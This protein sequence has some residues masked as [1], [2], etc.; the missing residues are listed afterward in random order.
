MFSLGLPEV[1]FQNASNVICLFFFFLLW[2]EHGA[3]NFKRVFDFTTGLRKALLVACQ[4][5]QSELSFSM[6]RTG[7]FFNGLMESLL[8]I[9]TKNKAKHEATR[10]LSRILGHFFKYFKAV[11]TVVS[12]QFPC[13]TVFVFNYF[14]FVHYLVPSTFYLVNSWTNLVWEFGKECSMKPKSA[15]HCFEIFL[16]LISTSF[17]FFFY[18]LLG[19]HE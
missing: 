9:K 7:I 16:S 8:W 18:L 14:F 17:I 10:T 11:F 1:T 2:R 3:S 13:L 5:P 19:I 4:K 12:Y 6:K 15:K